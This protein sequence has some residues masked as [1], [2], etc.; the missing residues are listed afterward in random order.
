[1]FHALY[2]IFARLHQT[3]LVRLANDRVALERA[4]ADQIRK[5]HDHVTATDEYDWPFWV[6]K[7]RSINRERH[8]REQR[9]SNVNIKKNFIQQLS[10]FR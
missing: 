10:S 5:A 3:V 4:R 8:Q 6:S 9:R 1:M 2:E 7:T